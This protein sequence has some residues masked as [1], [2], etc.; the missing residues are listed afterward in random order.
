MPSPG[1]LSHR[2]QST[3]WTPWLRVPRCPTVVVVDTHTE[4]NRLTVPVS[5]RVS[6]IVDP[7]VPKGVR[8]LMKLPSKTTVLWH[9]ETSLVCSHSHS[10][11]ELRPKPKVGALRSRLLQT[12]EKKKRC[13]T[14]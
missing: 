1:R 13:L 6:A 10:A 9:C 2:H 14:T 4:A 7:P 5:L 12:D 11:L 3:V 8:F